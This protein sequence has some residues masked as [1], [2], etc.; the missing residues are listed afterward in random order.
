MFTREKR[1]GNY[2]QIRHQGR[3]LSAKSQRMSRLQK[4]DKRNTS[5]VNVHCGFR[6]HGVLWWM[7]VGFDSWR[8]PCQCSPRFLVLLS[9]KTYVFLTLGLT[10]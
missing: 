8:R 7:S 10:I 9:F 5:K 4:M 3:L 1:E 6:K 2:R